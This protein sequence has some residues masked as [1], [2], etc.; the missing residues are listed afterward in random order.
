MR[1]FRFGLLIERFTDPKSVL[2][3]ARRAEA[4]GFA[5]FVIRDHLIDRPFGPQYAPWT[6]LAS[7]AQVTRTLRLGTMVIANDFRHPAVLAKEVTSLDQLSG[8]RV[9]LGLGAGF[10]REE[11]DRTGL[12]FHPNKVRVDRLAESVEVLDTLLSGR[13]LT[14]H[15]EHYSFDEFVNF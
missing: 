9:E 8:G 11:F 15:G 1:A 5:T 6:T 7:V 14:H 4:N 2:E 3:T 13:Q 10:L 12:T